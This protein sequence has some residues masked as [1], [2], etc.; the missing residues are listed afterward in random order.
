MGIKVQKCP[1]CGTNEWTPSPHACKECGY[2][3]PATNPM[4]TAELDKALLFALAALG[5]QDAILELGHFGNR[6][7]EEAIARLKYFRIELANF[8]KRSAQ[9]NQW[10]TVSGIY[11]DNG[12]RYTTFVE[13]K[14]SKEAEKLAQEECA[15]DNKMRT[16]TPLNIACVLAG[17]HEA[18][19]H[20][21]VYEGG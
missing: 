2:R 17:R 7:T 15:K 4:G 10:F 21:P 12:Q 16:K 13:A 14:N 6:T 3:L 11:K 18:L 9:T 19:D 20:D 1:K 5:D 8:S